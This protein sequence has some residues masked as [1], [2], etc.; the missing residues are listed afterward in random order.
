MATPFCSSGGAEPTPSHASNPQRHYPSCRRDREQQASGRGEKRGCTQLRR[1]RIASLAS[2][3][4][5]TYGEQSAWRSPIALH[6]FLRQC[7]PR[8]LPCDYEAYFLGPEFLDG[9]IH[10]AN[11]L[12]FVRTSVRRYPDHIYVLDSLHFF[13]S[14]WRSEIEHDQLQASLVM[15]W[16]EMMKAFDGT[17]ATCN[18]FE[19][20]G[21]EGV[22]VNAVP[23]PDVALN[24]VLTA[25]PCP[26]RS[27]LDEVFAEWINPRRSASHASTVL[28]FLLRVRMASHPLNIYSCNDVRVAANDR[29][30]WMPL[31]RVA[32][33]HIEKHFGGATLI[34][35]VELLESRG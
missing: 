34:R 21:H 12:E 9:V 2:R 6:S 10:L 19:N 3:I 29:S 16:L 26:A 24:S 27:T 5:A 1:S 31:V 17:V 20:K 32:T 8:Y 14:R 7:L 30:V 11:A 4:A 25:H 23:G 28:D 22:I 13:W 33:P 35:I 18:E 15:G